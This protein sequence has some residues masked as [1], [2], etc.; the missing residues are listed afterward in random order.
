MGPILARSSLP[1]N[2]EPK[3]KARAVAVEVESSRL[4]TGSFVAGIVAVAR[5]APG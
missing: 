2:R 3:L 4:M 5:Q 1:V